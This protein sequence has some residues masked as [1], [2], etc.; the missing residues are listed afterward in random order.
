M[1][2]KVEEVRTWDLDAA[3]RGSVVATGLECGT[4]SFN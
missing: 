3:R 2:G 4:Y 1:T